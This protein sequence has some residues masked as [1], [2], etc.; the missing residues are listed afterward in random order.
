MINFVSGVNYVWLQNYNYLGGRSVL[1][2]GTWACSPHPQGH[3]DTPLEKFCN[4]LCL[5]SIHHVI[6]YFD[7]HL[8][9]GDWETLMMEGGSFLPPPSLDETLFPQRYDTWHWPPHQYDILALTI[10]QQTSHYICARAIR[11]NIRHN[12]PSGLQPSGSTLLFDVNSIWLRHDSTIDKDYRWL[13]TGARV[14]AEQIRLYLLNIFTAGEG[15]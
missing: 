11:H 13:Y 14:Q 10:M 7:L 15:C 4:C 12:S 9:W 6:K 3:G 1:R 8:L 2:V 5:F